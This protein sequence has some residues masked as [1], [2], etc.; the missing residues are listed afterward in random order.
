MLLSHSP[1]AMSSE[2]HVPLAYHR[3][4]N[5]WGRK[6]DMDTHTHTYSGQIKG[7]RTMD[8]NQSKSGEQRRRRKVEGKHNVNR[9]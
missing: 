6:E 5:T 3:K 2:N 8:R 1:T 4:G 9:K 7:S